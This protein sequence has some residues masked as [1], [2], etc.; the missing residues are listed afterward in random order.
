MR[1]YLIENRKIKHSGFL[2]LE[3]ATIRVLNEQ[4]QEVI[5]AQRERTIRPDSAAVLIYHRDR[6]SFVFTHQFRYPISGNDPQFILEIPAGGIDEGEKAREAARREVYE[7]VGYRCN[8]LEEIAAVFSSPGTCSERIYIYFAEVG[9]EDQLSQGGGVVSE[10]EQI[11]VVYKDRKICLSQLL[12]ID[13][14]KTLI[15]LQWF[16]QHKDKIY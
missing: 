16:L 7:E 2:E 11:K 9:A 5:K 14:A 15:A 8:T 3:T 6:E 4:G 10:N 12:K 1:T 13:D